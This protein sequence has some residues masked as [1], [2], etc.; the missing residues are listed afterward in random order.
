ME[1]LKKFKDFQEKLSAN[2]KGSGGHLK[3]FKQIG[4]HTFEAF[5]ERLDKAY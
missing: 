5:I 4:P 2:N 1:E 3:D